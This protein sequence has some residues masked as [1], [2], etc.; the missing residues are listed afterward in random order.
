MVCELCTFSAVLGSFYRRYSVF[1]RFVPQ[2]SGHESMKNLVFSNHIPLRRQT[3]PRSF[4]NCHSRCNSVI[5]ASIFRDPQLCLHFYGEQ[6]N[7][8]KSVICD[9]RF[10]LLVSVCFCHQ[11]SP[12][13]GWAVQIEIFTR[14]LGFTSTCRIVWARFSN[15]A[16]SDTLSW[17]IYLCII[18]II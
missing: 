17:L 12:L 15:S 7:Q 3:C 10:V 13:V 4:V 5:R 9:K 2:F 1:Y 16:D 11:V 8:S 18:S 14:K 6:V